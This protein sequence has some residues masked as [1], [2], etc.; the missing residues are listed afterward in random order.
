MSRVF[1]PPTVMVIDDSEIVLSVTRN[2][3]EGAGFRVLTHSRPSGCVAL[4]LQERPQLVL[5]DVNMP[6]IGGDTIAK[7]FG[8]ARPNNDTIVLLYSSL[9]AAALDAKVKGCGAH[10]Y[11]QKT[12]DGYDFLRQLNVW[13]K[14]AAGLSSGRMRAVSPEPSDEDL[15]RPSGARPVAPP[16]T[17]SVE[18]AFDRASAAPAGR[19]SGTLP[20]HLPVVLFIDDDMAALSALRR[21]VQSE[22]YS[23]EFAL[24]G[25]QALRRILSATAPDLVV[26]DLLM[27]E[28]SGAD[29]YRR[30]VAADPRWAERF[31]FVTGAGI[32]PEVTDFLSG[33]TGV[34]LEK[35]VRG[36]RLRSVIRE[37][38]SS[39]ELAAGHASQ[40]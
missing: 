14:Q 27:P 7:L 25:T 13:L 19:T 6:L 22:P 11:I 38:L 23:V 18:P 17:P 1:G 39:L 37:G 40:K 36:E 9:S 10:G 3:L 12:E 4:I 30:A 8:K 32:V 20:I 15:A 31:V 21:E 28:P 2:V 5:I 16:I 29:V 34:V 33:F 35:P 24:S 26:S